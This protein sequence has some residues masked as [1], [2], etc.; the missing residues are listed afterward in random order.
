MIVDDGSRD[1]TAARLRADPEL[2]VSV[3]TNATA[4]GVARTRNRGL[5]SVKTPWV[6]FLDDDDVWASFHLRTVHDAVAAF[7]DVVATVSG[8]LTIDQ[9]RRPMKRHP[10]PRAHELPDSL[11]RKNVVGTPSRVALRTDAVRALGG[12]DVGLSLAAD[13]DM[14][15]RIVRAGRVASTDELS[16]GYTE[17]GANMHLIADLALNELP[18]LEQRYTEAA[19]ARLTE[20]C[21][22]WL[23]ESYR[24]SGQRVKAARW[25]VRSWR[26]TGSRRDVARAAGVLLGERFLR[27]SGFQHKEKMPEGLGTWLEELRDV[28]RLPLDVS[29]S[30]V[31]AD[32]S[33]SHDAVSA[34]N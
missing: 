1:G 12:F 17:H 16:V 30:A 18:R 13:W 9:A 6:C 24:R 22:P 33:R 21:S 23:A 8:S 31:L 7:P 11:Y 25:Y 28:D 14:W 15:L 10:A 5:E 4:Q 19:S 2:P 20:H 3:V 29:L 32:V 26:D 34:P 27:M